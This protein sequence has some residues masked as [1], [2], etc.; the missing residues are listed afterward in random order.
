MTDGSSSV[1]AK[2]LGL[3]A[4]APFRLVGRSEDVR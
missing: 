3:V 1:F 2:A 4:L